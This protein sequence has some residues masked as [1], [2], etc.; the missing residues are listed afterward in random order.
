MDCHGLSWTI[1]D[2]H[3]LSLTIMDYHG[4]EIALYREAKLQVFGSG[5]RT[6]IILG[7]LISDQF[8][9]HF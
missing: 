5:I 8:K 1:M 3:G 6:E 4:L 7:Q 9:T 2:Y